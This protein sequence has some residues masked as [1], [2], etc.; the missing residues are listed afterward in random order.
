MFATTA[1]ILLRGNTLWAAKT[2]SRLHIPSFRSAH[3]IYAP[4][5]SQQAMDARAAVDLVEARG[6]EES[7]S[8]AKRALDAALAQGEDPQLLLDR[9]YIQQIHGM[10]E[11]RAAI[12]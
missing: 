9:G 12:R 8:A 1:N 2:R 3:R 10:N 6:D 7:F 4:H 5:K 11:I